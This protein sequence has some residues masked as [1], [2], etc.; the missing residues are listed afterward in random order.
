MFDFLYP[1]MRWHDWKDRWPLAACSAFVQSGDLCWHVQRMGQGPVML[2]LHGTGSSSHSWRELMVRWAHTHT[3]VSLD[4]PGHAFT[5]MADSAHLSLPGM[6]RAVQALMHSLSLEPKVIVGHSAGAAVGAEMVL[7]GGPKPPALVAFNPAWMP[8]P[9]WAGWLFAPV[10]KLVTLNPLSGWLMA[11]PSAR[12]R[13]VEQLLLGTGSH[14]TPEGVHWYQ[15]LFAQAVH[16]R[17]VLSMMERWDLASWSPRLEALGSPV[18]IVCGQDDRM[19]DPDST[20]ALSRRLP[21]VQYEV[22]PGLGHLAHEEAPA[23]CAQRVS[24]W[25]LSLSS[26]TAH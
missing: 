14:L 11:R 10:A 3:V 6:A 25:L 12:S 4:L 9:G 18:L 16:V 24:D 2:L 5:G 21:R 13:R 26:E 22:W 17:G 23:R 8:M 15:V 19:V 1:P 20:Q 7:L